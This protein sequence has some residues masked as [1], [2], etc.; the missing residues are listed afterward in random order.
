[1]W[2]L[3]VKE[4]RGLEERKQMESEM[5]AVGHGQGRHV[6]GRHT[7]IITTLR[8]IMGG[9]DWQIRSQLSLVLAL[10]LILK[11]SSHI[12]QVSR[13]HFRCSSA[14]ADVKAKTRVGSH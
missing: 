11:V 13:Y 6:K 9:F 8:K 1:M 4:Q 14:S 10:T 7:G 2:T 12:L 5:P 3:A